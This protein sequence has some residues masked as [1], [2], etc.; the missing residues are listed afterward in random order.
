LLKT[1]VLCAAIAVAIILACFA[2][3]LL[4]RRKRRKLSDKNGRK[5]LAAHGVTMYSERDLNKITNERKLF[6]GGGN[7]GKVYEGRIDGKPSQLVAVKY[8]VVTTMRRNWLKDIQELAQQ[9]QDDDDG[10]V[11]EIKF[12]FRIRHINVVKLIGCCLETK[13]PI[14]V[15]ELVSNGSLE[16]RLHD[17]DKRFT[18]SLLKRLDIA[19]GSAEALS[20]IHSHGDHVHMAMSSPPT[21]SLMMT[22]IRRCLTLVRPSSCQSTGMLWPWLVIRDT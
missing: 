21:S 17:G 15:Y 19:I 14:L 22:S 8:S 6:L 16:K 3:F 4:Q 9:E 11:N 20:H 5:I 1:F 13:N 2:G 18:L 10:F 12:Q 7:Y